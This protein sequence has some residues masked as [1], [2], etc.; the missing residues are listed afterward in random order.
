MLGSQKW[1]SKYVYYDFIIVNK[2]SALVEKISHLTCLW[3][4]YGVQCTKYNQSII[5]YKLDTEN[6]LND[7]LT[8][9]ENY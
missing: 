6:G 4:L 7:F 5:M 9:V 2:F 8:E 1:P 3:Y